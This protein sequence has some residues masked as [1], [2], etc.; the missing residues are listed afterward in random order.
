MRACLANWLGGW[1]ADWLADWLTGPE[2]SILL[3]TEGQIA[4]SVIANP[5]CSVRPEIRALRWYQID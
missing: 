3:N 4:N 2:Q 5:E 1:V